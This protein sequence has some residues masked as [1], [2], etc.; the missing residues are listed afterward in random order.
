MKRR[1]FLKRSALAGTSAASTPY[2]I[3]SHEASAAEATMPD[4]V[5]VKNAEPDIMLDKAMAEFGG[6]ERFVKKGQSIVIKPNIAWDRPPELGANTHPGLVKRVV[7]HCVKAGAKKVYVLD[8]TVNKS[9]SC[10]D[11]S[12]IE[13][14]AR[15]GGA[16]VVPVNTEG[17]YQKVEV[18]GETLKETAVHEQ[19]LEA[20][21]L[22]NVPVIKHHVSAKVTLSMKNLM[23]AIWDR[24]AYHKQGLHACIAEFCLF[25]KPDLNIVDGYRVTLRNG[26]QRA[27]PEDVV[28]KKTLLVSTDCVAVDTAAAKIQGTDPQ[29]VEHIVMAAEK[30]IGVMD[31]GKLNIKRITV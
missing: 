18:P 20:D 17:R 27:R 31:L 26:P 28:L 15:E 5:A 25:R 13:A 2:L 11:K 8:H 29:K 9:A 22:I 16:V 19:I 23:G 21:V 7:E 14:A 1:S 6:M 3:L 24:R 12:G 30:K 10:Y 4:L